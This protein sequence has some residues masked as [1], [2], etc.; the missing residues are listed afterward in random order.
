MPLPMEYVRGMPLKGPRTLTMAAN[1]DLYLALREGNAIFRID[2]KTQTLHRVAG[3]GEQGYS[4]DGGPALK[5][6]LSG[7]KG[8]AYAPGDA[9]ISRIPR[10]TRSAG[11]TCGPGSFPGARDWRSGRRS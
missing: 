6:K 7:P 10:V 11:S 3:T 9:C 1:G 2:A 4:G 5:A 8:L